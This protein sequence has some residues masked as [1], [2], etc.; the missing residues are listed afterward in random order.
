MKMTSYWLDTALPFASGA[1]GGPVGTADVAVV[2]AGFTGLSA[3][4]AL[5]RKGAKVVVLEA[6][7]VANAASGRNGGMCNNGFA[8]D[9]RAMAARLGRE[10]TNLLYRAFDASVDK[11][12]AII[13][14]EGI[15]CHFRRVGKLK[16]AA[17][18]EHY[19]K[20][21]RTQEVMAR[22][23]DPETRMVPRSEMHEEIGSD[24]YFGGMLIEKSAA[25]HMGEY[26]QGLAEAA[27]RRGALIYENNP[28]I[29]LRCLAGQAHEVRTPSGSIRADQVLLA[30]GTSRIGPLGWFRRRIVPVGAFIIATEPLS[31]E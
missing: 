10:P 8:Q 7:R 25:M 21:A 12:E 11:V 13:A 1:P 31:K 4:L 14:E 17:K 28:V 19:D 3:A 15:D 26:G 30:T 18:P 24:R 16:L 2:G 6:G 20:L 5:A 29:E 27:A 9:Y 22:E 23:V